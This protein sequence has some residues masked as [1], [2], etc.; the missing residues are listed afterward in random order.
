MTKQVKQYYSTILMFIIVIILLPVILAF[1]ANHREI[2][3]LKHQYQTEYVCDNAV[4]TN[5]FNNCH[6]LENKY[7]TEYL[8]NTNQSNCW[9]EVK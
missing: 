3:N 4:T 7:N 9:V 2:D 8:C 6:A 5:K 1:R